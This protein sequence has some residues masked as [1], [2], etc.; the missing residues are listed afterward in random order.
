MPAEI[1]HTSQSSESRQ[2][3]KRSPDA[4][5][6][7]PSP[8]MR[9]GQLTA[10]TQSD[11]YGIFANSF[12]PG[13][14]RTSSLFECHGNPAPEDAMHP[15]YA[16]SYRPIWSIGDWKRADNDATVPVKLPCAMQFRDSV[17]W[18]YESEDTLT[19]FDMTYQRLP[20]VDVHAQ[21]DYN[22]TNTHVCST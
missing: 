16:Q 19:P 4:R 17:K 11:H 21:H 12:E 5:Q 8:T 1:P 15:L 3:Y 9:P 14:L 18:E 10:A 2:H 13:R 22:D 6:Q 7:Q 20:A